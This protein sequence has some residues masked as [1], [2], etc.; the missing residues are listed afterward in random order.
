MS[1]PDNNDFGKTHFPPVDDPSNEETGKSE[2]YPKNLQDEINE[3]YNHN[4]V[5]P[6]EAGVDYTEE[7]DEGESYQ[8]PDDANQEEKYS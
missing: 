4:K 8:N 6:R 7:K 1:F 3:A 2:L 5:L